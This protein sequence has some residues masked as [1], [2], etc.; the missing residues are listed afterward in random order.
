MRKLIR[1]LLTLTIVLGVFVGTP[2]KVEAKAGFDI[3]KHV[4]EMEVHEDGSILVTETMDVHFLTS[5][6]GIYINVPKRYNMHWDING[7]E[8]YKSY[9]FPIRK[10]KVLSNHKYEKTNFDAGIQIK[11]GDANKYANEYETYKFQY[12]IVTRDLDLDG[13]Q[14]LFMNIVSGNW[15]ADTHSVEFTIQMPKEFDRT[16]L[17][18]DSPMG[19]TGTSSGALTVVVSGNTISGSY[20]ETLKAGEALTVQLMLGENYFEFASLNYF[21]LI[22]AI[23]ACA[24]TL[25]YAILFHLFG[26]DDPMIESVEFHAPAGVTSAEVG[27]IIDGVAN[28]GDVISL[29]LDWGRRGI[30]SIIDDE[31]GLRLKKLT[32]L[33]K[34]AKNYERT[35]FNALF[36]NKDVVV[37]KDLKEKF[38]RTI[39]KT[40]KQLDKYFDANKR[41]LFTQTS[42]LLQSVMSAVCCL[43]VAVAVFLI[44]Y[45]YSYDLAV[46]II[47]SA[48][49]GVFIVVSSMIMNYMDDKR[50]M[51]RWYTKTLLYVTVALLFLASSFILVYVTGLAKINM[52]YALAIILLSFVMVII[53]RQMKKRTEYGNELLGQI[54]GLRNFII[55]AEQDRLVELLDENPYYFYDILPFAYALGLTDVWNEHFKYLTMEPCSWYVCSYHSSPYHMMHSLESQMT[56]MERSMTSAPS[57]SSGG[58]SSS[59]SSGFSGGGFGGS[60]GGGW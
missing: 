2:K 49:A 11:I 13:I 51:H 30:I 58:Y 46:A 12:E 29:I 23:V 41:R 35:M 32:D 24:S 37:V 52:V 16:K 59:G 57:E 8:Q 1:I 55:V 4:V 54:V 34:G 45:N 47:V 48:I 21:G 6:H 14:M 38:Y 50:Y 60:G 31:D 27:V 10:V 25:I 20:S 56:V 28:D 15:E 39:Q 33:E 7:I 26:K 5:L 40:E 19:I 36:N 9:K 42:I 22:G 18:F 3:D 17:Q 53:T 44:D 43:P